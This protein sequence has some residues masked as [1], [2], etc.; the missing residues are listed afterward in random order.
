MLPAI[1]EVLLGTQEPF[2]SLAWLP[3]TFNPLQAPLTA[4]PQQTHDGKDRFCCSPSLS[5][6]GTGIHVLPE[7]TGGCEHVFDQTTRYSRR[8]TIIINKKK[9]SLQT[10][11][12]TKKGWAS[13]QQQDDQQWPAPPCCSAP[14]HLQKAH[15][16]EISQQHPHLPLGTKPFQASGKKQ[17]QAVLEATT[18]TQTCQT[19]Q[20]WRQTGCTK[21]R[22]W[23]WN[24]Q[25][26]PN[27]T[28]KVQ[29]PWLRARS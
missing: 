7:L 3:K 29:A 9:G 23:G 24:A 5:G 16:T 19:L 1:V 17:A 11:R 6:Q 20:M 26:H 4:A 14:K 18:A 8:T 2:Q 12:Q 21:G 25:G 10:K 15:S 27:T 13:I 22:C 28:S